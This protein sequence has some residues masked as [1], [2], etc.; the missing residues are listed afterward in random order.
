M[1]KGG[2]EKCANSFCEQLSETGTVLFLNG[3][4]VGHAGFSRYSESVFV[5]KA[6]DI[7]TVEGHTVRYVRSEVVPRVHIPVLCKI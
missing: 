7:S 4:A 3:Q 5:G 1:V 6:A 2:T